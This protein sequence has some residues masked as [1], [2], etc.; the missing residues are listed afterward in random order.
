MSRF[1]V[2][3]RG[4][5]VGKANRVPME[6][7]RRL[8]EELEYTDVRTLLNS[9]NAVFTAPGRSASA[10]AGAIAK[11]LQAS[12][13]VAVPVIVRTSGD[14]DAIVAQCPIAPPDEHHSRFLIAFPPSGEV[15]QTLVSI[16]PLVQAPERFVVGKHAAYLYCVQGILQSKAATAL[17]GKAGRALTTRNWA[18]VLKLRELLDVR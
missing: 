9:G 13:G 2:L 5:N 7:F 15:L 11:S 8:L 10:H 16:A 14:F 1:V 6:R 17:L 4:V 12:L 3:L 18:T